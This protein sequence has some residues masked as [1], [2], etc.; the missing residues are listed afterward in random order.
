M[1][2]VRLNKFLSEAGVCSRREADRL[3]E[4][5]KVSVDGETAVTGM[6]VREEQRILVN[7]RPVCKEEEM[8]LLVV[9]KPRGIVCTAEKREKNNIIEYLHY[10]KRI[11]PVGRLDKDSEGLLLMTN[12]GEIVNKIMRSGNRHEKEYVVTVNKEVTEEFVRAMAGGIPILD[13]VTRKCEVQKLDKHRFRIVLTQG[14]NR[15]I[16]R[17]CEYLGYRVVALTRVRI[18]NIRL[19]NLKPGAYRRVTAQEWR[20]L[21]EL[22]RDS[23]NTTVIEERKNG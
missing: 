4:A 15:Q 20:T 10:P 11:Y 9:N 17:M 19:G 22:I 14:L 21:Q 1:E 2:E 13:T 6:K 3:I 16:R 18:M 12:N 7:G 8:I 5:G 23:S